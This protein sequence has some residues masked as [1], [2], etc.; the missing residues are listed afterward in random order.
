MEP[1]SLRKSARRVI[2]RNSHRLARIVEDF[3]HDRLDARQERALKD[4]SGDLTALATH[5]GTDKWG[6]HRYAQ[7]YQRHLEH[8]RNRPI[9]LLE[10]GVGGYA[11]PAKGG[12]SL[13]MWKQ[14]FPQGEI[15]GLDLHDKSQLQE[16]RVHIFR[17]DQ[18]DPGSLRRAAEQ[19]GRI[20]VIIDD[21]SHLSPHVITTFETLFPLLDAHGIYII[22]DLQTSYWPEWSGSEDR[23][24]PDTSMALLKRLVDGLNHEEFVEEGYEPTYTDQHVVAAHFYHNVAILQKGFNAEGT[25]KQ[26]ILKD[27]YA[28]A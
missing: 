27:R 21:G 9:N 23:G 15:F 14:F 4:I 20:D 28:G 25:R 13:R 19:I 3:Q 11:N 18:S 26:K 6:S 22:E 2:R 24:A 17:G 1:K 10:I 5:F 12:E 8:L 7:H 16:P